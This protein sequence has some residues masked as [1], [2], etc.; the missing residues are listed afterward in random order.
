[1][2]LNNNSRIHKI[3]DKVS[4]ISIESSIDEESKIINSIIGHNCHI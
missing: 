2:T 1:M 3:G 4:V